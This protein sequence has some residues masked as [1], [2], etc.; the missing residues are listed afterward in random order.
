MIRGS[1]LCGA[2]AY[3]ADGAFEEVHHCH[4]TRCRKHHG[5]AFA[6]YARVAAAGFRFVRG[7]E[8]VRSHRSSPPVARTF[9][10]TCGSN[11]QFVHDD[12]PDAVW[13]AAGSLDEAPPLRPEAHLFFASR[14]PWHEVRDELPR[15]D[16]LP[17]QE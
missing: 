6:T 15:H 12:V 4:C 14:V 3:E 2:V 8:H 1:C 13:L 17:P 7:A 11:L 5:A 9:C 16:A 10:G